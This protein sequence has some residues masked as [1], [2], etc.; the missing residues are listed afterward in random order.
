[1]GVGLRKGNSALKAKLDSALCAMINS[2]KVKAA[3]ENWFKDDYTIA[4][5]K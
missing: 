5:K 4:C 1:M 3:S 2:G